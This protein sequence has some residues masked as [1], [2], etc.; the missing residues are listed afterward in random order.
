MAVL[1]DVGKVGIC[2]ASA[3]VGR[4][5]VALSAEND[6]SAAAVFEAYT[7]TVVVFVINVVAMVVV[8]I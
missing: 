2:V 6:A 7:D 5:R 3:G 8:E 4:E 1:V